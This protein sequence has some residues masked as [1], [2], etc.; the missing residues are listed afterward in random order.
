MTWAPEA[1]LLTGT[2][3][4]ALAL[5]AATTAVEPARDRILLVAIQKVRRLTGAVGMVAGPR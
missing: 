3:G 5:L 2:A 4:I 1:G